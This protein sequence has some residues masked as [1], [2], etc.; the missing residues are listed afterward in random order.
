VAYVVV[1]NPFHVSQTQRQHG[2]DALQGLDL[3][4]LIHARHERVI[5]QIEIQAYDVADFLDEEW[6]SGEL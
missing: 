6:I 4:L 3:A 1:G 2:L 5:G